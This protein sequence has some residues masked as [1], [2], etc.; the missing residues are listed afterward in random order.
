MWWCCNYLMP[1]KFINIPVS[2]LNGHW[3]PTHRHQWKTEVKVW[4]VSNMNKL[5]WCLITIRF[6][7]HRSSSSWLSGQRLGDSSNKF[8]RWLIHGFTSN[9]AQCLQKVICCCI[10]KFDT[11]RK[12]CTKTMWKRRKLCNLISHKQIST[13]L[14][15]TYIN[16]WHWHENKSGGEL[17]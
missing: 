5:P 4:N 14:S 9:Q 8:V 2:Q 1:E 10:N 15:T 17:Y 6:G 13:N 3:S 12:N 7:C 16:L 11:Y